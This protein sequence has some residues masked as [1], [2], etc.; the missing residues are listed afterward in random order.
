M[1]RTKSPIKGR[2]L[3]NP[4]DLLKNSVDEFFDRHIGVYIVLFF[5]LFLF[6][7]LEW[8]RWYSQNP[9]SPVGVTILTTPI[10][11]F[12]VYKIFSGIRKGKKM[13]MG[14][15]GEKAVGQFLERFRAG[16][17]QVFHDIQCDGFNLDHVLIHPAGIYVIETKTMSK[18]T[19]GR[20]ELEFTGTQILRGGRP[21]KGDAVTQASSAAKWLRDELLESTGR[22]FYVK[23]IVVYPGWFIKSKRNLTSL[24]T[25]V[26]NPKA[27]PGILSAQKI[28]LAQEDIHLCSYHLSRY[29]RTYSN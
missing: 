27:L 1:K 12:C 3:N 26:L 9:P 7:V 5:V 18:P 20:A 14:W 25:W 6:V 19:K 24:S 28:Q 10:I 21:I 16:G 8:L 15:R 11:L 29:I 2:V 4:G 22:V 23:G 13:V 17:A